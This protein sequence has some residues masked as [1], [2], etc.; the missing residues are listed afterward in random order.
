MAGLSYEDLIKKR[1]GQYVSRKDHKGL[2]AMSFQKDEKELLMVHFT[3][4]PN[5]P[6]VTTVNYSLKDPTMSPG[7]FRDIVLQR[8]NIKT[9]ENKRFPDQA[10]SGTRNF[11]VDGILVHENLRIH[12]RPGAGKL[13]LAENNLG[14]AGK[15]DQK[16]YNAALDAAI[17]KSESKTSF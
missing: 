14:L 17:P 13:G 4:F 9:N 12:S 7:Q 10:W 2:G 6:R 15:I 8:Y 16:A 1:Q 11:A 3:A 5:G